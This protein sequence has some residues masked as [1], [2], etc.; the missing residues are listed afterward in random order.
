MEKRSYKFKER[1]GWVNTPE[2]AK[3]LGCSRDYLI[4]HKHDL[5]KGLWYNMKPQYP[6][7]AYR[8]NIEG[9][10]QRLIELSNGSE[11]TN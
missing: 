9:I 10:R 1:E 2:A 3:A 4:N 5:F 11:T 7:P 8:W 6:R